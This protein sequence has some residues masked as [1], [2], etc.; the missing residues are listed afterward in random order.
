MYQL[1]PDLIILIWHQNW[2]QLSH[3]IPIFTVDNWHQL[4]PSRFFTSWS[5]LARDDARTGQ[6][7]GDVTVRNLGARELDGFEVKKK[8]SGYDEQFA[9]GCWWP[10]AIDG[11]PNLKMV[12]FS[13]GLLMALIEIDG[14]PNL[15]MLKNGDFHWFSMA[16]LNNQRANALNVLNLPSVIECYRVFMTWSELASRHEGTW[17]W[18]DSN[19]QP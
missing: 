18:A 17:W 7:H 11:L 10:I 12:I 19:I 2:H 14:L 6:A 8:T 5:S 9:M 16:V 4:T 15:K 3:I 1:R 13:H